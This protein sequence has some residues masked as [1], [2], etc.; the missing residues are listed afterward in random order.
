M[1][2]KNQRRKPLKK[3]PDNDARVRKCI[4]TGV[5]GSPEGYVRFVLDPDGVVTPDFSGTLPGRGAWVSASRAAVEKAVKEG[6]FAKSFKQSAK[7]PDDLSDRVEAGLA[8]AALSA[9]GLARKAGDAVLGF[10]KVRA[11]LKGNDITVLVSAADGARDGK[12]KLQRLAKNAAKIGV[13]REGELAAAL[14]RDGIVHIA[15]KSGPAALR[16]MREARC[17]RGFREEPVWAE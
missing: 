8:K 12:S 7:A 1:R 2:K 5:V 6:A 4:A 11:A 15:L 14:G 16:F 10:E 3:A 17:V 13:F 9:L